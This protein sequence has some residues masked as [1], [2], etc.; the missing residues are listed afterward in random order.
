MDDNEEMDLDVFESALLDCWEEAQEEMKNDR[1]DGGVSSSLLPPLPAESTRTSWYSNPNDSQQ[2]LYRLPS[3][4]MEDEV[5][6]QRSVGMPDSRTMTNASVVTNKDSSTTSGVS[7]SADST[8]ST[9]AS[10]LLATTAP[11]G[12]D[13]AIP[14]FSQPDASGYVSSQRTSASSTHLHPL[15]ISSSA[16]C[17]PHAAAAEAAAVPQPAQRLD[18][19]LLPLALN[20]L[21]A[22]V[23]FSQFLHAPNHLPTLN[24]MNGPTLT[25]PSVDAAQNPVYAR[26]HAGAAVLSNDQHRIPPFLLFDAPIELRTNFIRSQRAHGFQP[27][28]DNNQ[29]HF[30]LTVNGFHPRQDGRPTPV[31]GQLGENVRLIDAR[32]GDQGSKRQKNAKEQKRAQRITDLIE[33]LRGKME[34]GGWQVGL[35]SK[36]HTLSS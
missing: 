13:R 29:Y 28:D 10:E 30:G 12:T 3:F 27:L 4:V 18:P 15:G 33:Q 5:A 19:S 14:T 9:L 23:D 20:A 32:Y 25:I 21:K 8:N 1:E 36:L 26:S 34:K 31:P 17:P 7:S 22:G 2:S 24:D 6:Y 35:K 11:H 16:V